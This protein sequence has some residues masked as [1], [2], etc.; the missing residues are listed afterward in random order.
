[1]PKMNVPEEENDTE[2]REAEAAWLGGAC[3][4]A[5]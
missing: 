1:M 5:V 2:M 4:K 3:V